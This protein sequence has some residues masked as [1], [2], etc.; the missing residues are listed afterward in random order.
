VPPP[1]P[2]PAALQ[3]RGREAQLRAALAA[4]DA[5]GAGS[6][7]GAQFEAALSAA[8]LRFTRH[9]AVALLRRADRERAGR[10]ATEDLVAL[11]ALGGGAPR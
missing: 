10:V 9:Q 4:A 7:T 1:P 2:A 5:E 3:A 11:L 6:L 8:G